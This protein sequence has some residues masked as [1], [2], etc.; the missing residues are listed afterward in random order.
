MRDDYQA[1][2]AQELREAID[3]LASPLD[4]YGFASTGVYIF[5]D[6]DTKDILYIGLARD[7][8]ERFAQRNALIKMAAKSCKASSDH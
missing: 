6:P 2:E 8:S 5:F 3:D 1:H 4:T 7:L